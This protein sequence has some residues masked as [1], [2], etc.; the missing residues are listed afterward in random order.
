MKFTGIDWKEFTETFEI[1]DESTARLL[2]LETIVRLGAQDKD[3]NRFKVSKIAIRCAK[4]VA[5]EAGCRRELYGLNVFGLLTPAMHDEL[6]GLARKAVF[7]RFPF[8]V[9]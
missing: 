4:L 2:K 3:G 1:K 6:N 9:K 8:D 5:D 7:D